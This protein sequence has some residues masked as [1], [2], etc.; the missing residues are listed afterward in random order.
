MRPS[1]APGGPPRWRPTFRGRRLRRLQVRLLGWFLGA[2]ILAIG[3]SVTVAYLTSNDNDTPTR[4][5]SRHVQHTLARNWD[6]P[7]ATEEYVAEL[8]ETTGLDMH[9]RRDPNLFPPGRRFRANNGG[10]MIFEDG[11]A[12][13]PVMKNGNVVG[14]L[15]LRTGTAT[16]QWWRVVVALGAA[17]LVLGVV[18]G[19][20]SKRL[21]RP[22]EHLAQTA[23]RF[24]SGDLSARTGIEHLP[25]RWVAEEVR[26]V[27]RA[28]DGMADRIARV[29]LEQRELLA[30]ISHE[31]RSP[32]GRARIAV[33]IARDRP[34]PGSALDDV[35]RQ[36]VEMDSIL[37][38]LLASAR[39]GLADVHLED[40]AIVSW[41][42]KRVA[43]EKEG[44]IEMT[45]PPAAEAAL[46][47]IDAALLGRAVH[48]L[49]GNAWNHGHPKDQPLEVTVALEGQRVRVTLRDRG[50]GFRAELLPRAFEP[51]VM[52]ADS[53]RSPGAHGMGLGLSLVRRIVEAHG[54]LASA[55][56]VVEN[57]VVRGAEVTIELPLIGP[58]HAGSIRS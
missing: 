21:A 48:N 36:L 49:L 3:A 22:L 25:R 46:V 32:L 31:L 11:V 8:R 5:V 50:P 29:V 57:E 33:E 14:A 54:G 39:A 47:K 35:E 37:G 9:V 18:A 34:E 17:I 1:G 19:R 38:D 15:E 30:A 42:R 52:G 51:F 44:P 26:D 13:W 27:G 23:E 58:S 41:L 45:V 4:V 10:G 40:V 43:T 20:V 12:Y 2:I 7:V 28:F 55:A 53:A 56:N 24:G 6:D 16:P